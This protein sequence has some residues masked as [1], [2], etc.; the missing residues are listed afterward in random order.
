MK[1]ILF[2]DDDDTF[3]LLMDHIAK[4]N[5]VKLDKCA[6]PVSAMTMIDLDNYDSIFI[7]QRLSSCFNGTES[8]CII[9]EK[10]PH[11]DLYLVTNYPIESLRKEL[12]N[13]KI[14]GFIDKHYLSEKMDE[15]LK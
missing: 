7:D 11:L 12:E 4:R 5:G 8:I 9:S 2:V 1:K 13:L 3:Q 6:D 10:H 14:K 15:V